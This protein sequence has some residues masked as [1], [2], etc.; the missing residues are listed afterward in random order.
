MN[1]QMNNQTSHTALLPILTLYL[2]ESEK[3]KLSPKLAEVRKKKKKSR[4]DINE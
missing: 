1:E 2:K 4:A 3:D